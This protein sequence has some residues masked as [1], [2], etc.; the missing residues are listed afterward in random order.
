MSTSV[1]YPPDPYPSEPYQSTATVGA[2]DAA[3]QDSAER[4]AWWLALGGALT[5]VLLGIM[6]IAWPDATLKVVAALFGIWLLLHGGVRI[7]QAITATARDGGERAILGVIGVLFVVAGVIAL[8]NL[9]VSLA[10][11]ITLVGL[12]WLIGGLVELVSAFGR[13]GS[14]HRVLHVVLGGL[15]IVGAL[16]VMVW[17]GLS[18]TTLVYVTGAWLIVMGLLQVAL[19]VWARRSV[20][21]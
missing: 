20:A 19:V 9:L 4:V 13:R 8:R 12:M 2:A 21:S 5:S 18:L 11:V 6:M 17:P 3:A 10:V 16:I 15:G 7:V 14:G 1:P